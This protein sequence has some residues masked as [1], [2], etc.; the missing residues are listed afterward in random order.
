MVLITIY[1]VVVSD[2]INFA[3]EYRPVWSSTVV[4][5]HQ[6]PTQKLEWHSHEDYMNYNP[7]NI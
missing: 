7:V 2:P 3:S 4:I 6:L 1:F 5:G